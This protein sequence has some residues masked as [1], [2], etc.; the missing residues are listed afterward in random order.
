MTE[1]AIITTLIVVILQI[2]TISLLRSTR[3]MVREFAEKKTGNSFNNERKDRDP[4]Q[5]QRRS[6]T[7]NKNRSQMH[8]NANAT[9]ATA[10]PVEKSLRDINLKLKNAERDQEFARRKIQDNFSKDTNRRRDGG[11]NG[12]DQRRGDRRSNWNEKNSRR[13]NP[14]TMVES[15]INAENEEISKPV[16]T[17]IQEVSKDITPVAPELVPIDFGT[18]ENLQHGRK[19]APKRKF[20]S[21]ENTAGT[22][23][24][25][26]EQFTQEKTDSTE[27]TVESE[28]KFGRR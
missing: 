11:K 15:Q 8:G 16:E 25:A 18:E 24:P 28:I 19:F 6:G 7:D 13:D 2:I 4:R 21:E 10:D 1:A 17:P 22:P 14:K 26:Q 23:E 3:K 27:K 12:R 5:N 20:L 9:T